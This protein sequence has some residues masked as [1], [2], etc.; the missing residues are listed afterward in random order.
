MKTEHLKLILLLHI[1]LLGYSL[2]G[3]FSK[4]AAKESFLSKPFI[5]YYGMVLFI[6]FLYAVLWQQILKKLPLVVAYVNKAVT[7]VWGLVWGY[8]F[9]QENITIRKVIASM[10][11]IVGIICITTEQED[12]T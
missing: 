6:L 1:V 3:I 4:M 11:I 8:V 2:G 12:E 9:F 5:A 7:V 10:I